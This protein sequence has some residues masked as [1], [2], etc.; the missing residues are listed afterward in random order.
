LLAACGGTGRAVRVSNPSGTAAPHLKVQFRALPTMDQCQ[1]LKGARC[2]RA[3]QL[4]TAYGVD[5]LAGLT[6]KGRTIAVLDFSGSPTL[7]NDLEVYSRVMGLP[8]PQLQIMAQG[9]GK[10]PAFDPDDEQGDVFNA[11]E[12]TLDLEAAHAMAPEAKLVLMTANLDELARTATPRTP[13]G[14]LNAT[15]EL[16]AAA[17]E[18]VTRRAAPDVISLS[19]GQPE[20]LYGSDLR[21]VRALHTRLR[22]IV[23]SGT[24]ILACS[25]D[26][27][28][29]I[30]YGG[31]GKPVRTVDW[32]ASDPAVVGVGGSYLQ[33]TQ[34]GRRIAPD[35][36]WN[37]SQGK[38]GRGAA[39]G[40]VS[41]IF[42][43]PSYQNTVKDRTGTARGVPDAALSASPRGGILLYTSFLPE[44]GWLI[45]GGTSEATPLF[46]GIVA[47]AAQRAGH[48]LGD[49]H[50]DLYKGT[51]IV[52]IT[53]GVNGVDGYPARKGYDLASGLGT[54]DAAAL[55]PALAG[56]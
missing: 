30:N 44:P 25:G 35:Q 9:T 14:V 10:P 50:D 19:Y 16:L 12:T 28:A 3:A 55:V 39:G 36:V 26:D 33:L 37:D 4:R 47:L 18:E 7:R 17:M 6:G 24:A 48:R 49:I 32:P 51:G 29:A 42:A 2:Y 20:L 1:A 56:R 15:G 23:G 38:A 45:L 31:T 53:Q 5:R 41:T 54:V 8:K 34:D 40:G 13:T 21:A 22:A 11:I 27:G 43:R 46:A 52:D